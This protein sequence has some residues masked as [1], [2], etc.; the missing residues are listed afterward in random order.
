MGAMA[1][2]QTRGRNSLPFLIW[3]PTLLLA[4]ERRMPRLLQVRSHFMAGLFRPIFLQTIHIA[5]HVVHAPRC[6]ELLDRAVEGLLLLFGGKHPSV[7][8]ELCA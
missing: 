3:D 4:A 7:A 5:A 2:P 8:L 1:D 6:K